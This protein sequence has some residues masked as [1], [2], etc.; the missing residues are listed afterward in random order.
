MKRLT[1]VLIILC[2]CGSPASKSNTGQQKP[3]KITRIVWESS[4]EK[5]GLDYRAKLDGHELC[6]N[7]D[8]DGEG[9]LSIDGHVVSWYGK[10]EELKALSPDKIRAFFPKIEELKQ[11]AAQ[12]RDDK[13]RAELERKKKQEEQKK[14]WDEQNAERQ[15]KQDQLRL[16]REQLQLEKAKLEAAKADAIVKRKREL[17][18]VGIKPGKRFS[19]EIGKDGLVGSMGF[20]NYTVIEIKISTDGDYTV[21]ARRDGVGKSTSFSSSQI[22]S[23]P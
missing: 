1:F 3:D 20:W 18:L 10:L 7:P 9:T 23:L 22:P 4:I 5:G 16:E 6:I 15:L 13:K 17:E 14:L 2:G 8:R 12:Q 19:Y 11:K 21:I